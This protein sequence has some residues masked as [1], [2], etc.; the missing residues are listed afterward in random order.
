L[1]AMSAAI[2]VVARPATSTSDK[3]TFFITCP[4]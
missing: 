1:V 2:A 4:F 3:A